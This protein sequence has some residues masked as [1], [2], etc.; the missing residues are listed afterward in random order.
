MLLGWGS[1]AFTIA[2]ERNCM[3][4]TRNEIIE[5]LQHNK[6]IVK[7]TKV[8]GEIREMPCTLR[9]DI[10]PKFEPK[11]TSR[12]KKPNDQVVSAWCLDRQ[13]WRS[14]RVD[15]VQELRIDFGMPTVLV[16]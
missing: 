14:F 10:I 3:I 2:R 4:L 15:S 7:F 16:K 8:N 9:E 13:E 6:C 12:P 5:A 11:E 1:D